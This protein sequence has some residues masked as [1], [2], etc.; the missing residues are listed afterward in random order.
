VIR[1]ARV[2]LHPLV[3]AALAVL[4]VNDHVLK[5][6]FPGLVTGKLSDFAGMVIAPLVLFAMV[7]ERVAPLRVRVWACVAIVAVAF[8]LAKTWEPATHAYEDV[9]AWTRAPLR[10]VLS[11][12][13][14]RPTW[15]ERI[16]LVRDPTDLAALP[17]GAIAGWIGRGVS[18]SRTITATST[19]TSTNKNAVSTRRGAGGLDSGARS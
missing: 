13:L 15:N 1:R 19:T 7:P 8:A 18:T 6:D 3:L 17:F 12:V 14:H 10:L 16:I 9:L 2:L 11:I 4:V 5:H